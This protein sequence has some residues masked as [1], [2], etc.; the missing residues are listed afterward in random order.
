MYCLIQLFSWWMC[1]V[2][3]LFWKI[4]HPYHAQ[5]FE[6]ARRD[7]YIHILCL[8]IGFLLPLVPI[9]T[10]MAKFA[11]DVESSESPRSKNVT[12]ASGGMGFGVAHFPPVY[13]F[14]VDRGATFYSFILLHDGIVAVGTTILI[15]IFW[16][17]HKVSNISYLQLLQL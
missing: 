17:I 7:K 13:C 16:S 6:A 10:T 12:F 11:V 14:G 5:S 15:L 1:H 9:V 8:L 3:V 4:Q 2:I